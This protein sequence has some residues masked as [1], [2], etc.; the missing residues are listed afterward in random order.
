[1]SQIL[2]Y[3][4]KS[5]AAFLNNMTQVKKAWDSELNPWK[6]INLCNQI[7]FLVLIRIRWSSGLRFPKGRGEITQASSTLRL[8]PC[9]TQ[10]SWWLFSASSNAY[11]SCLFCG[12]RDGTTK[13]WPAF[14]SSLAPTGGPFAR[15]VRCCS[16][17]SVPHPIQWARA[18]EERVRT[19][20]S[21]GTLL[22]TGSSLEL[23]PLLRVGL[24]GCP[25]SLGRILLH[26]SLLGHEGLKTPYKVKHGLSSILRKVCVLLT[27]LPSSPEHIP[28]GIE[29]PITTKYRFSRSAH[30]IHISWQRKLYINLCN[31][32]R[33]K[34]LWSDALACNEQL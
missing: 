22:L 28:V 9:F 8:Y 3:C 18:V 27:L 16:G 15:G 21:R 24:W 25:S 30:D 29:A 33:K 14:T 34:Q 26:V 19:Y 7:K 20:S 23:P 12:P 17:A 4:S 32:C 1:M 5:I 10:G 11:A 2:Y 31:C 13:Y 6:F